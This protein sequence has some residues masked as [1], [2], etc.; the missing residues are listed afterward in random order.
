M[1]SKMGR[2]IKDNSKQY[3]LRVRIKEETLKK[4][5]TCCK[6]Q[7]KSCSQVVRECIEEKFNSIKNKIN[8]DLI[9]AD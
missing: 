2:I 1:S 8:R 7:N 3:M 9:L 6:N 4:L 5:D